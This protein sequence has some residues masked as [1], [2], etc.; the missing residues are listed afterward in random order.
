MIWL[1]EML[2]RDPDWE[3]PWDKIEKSLLASLFRA[4]GETPQNPRYHGEGDVWT[5]TKQVCTALTGLEAFRQESPRGQAVLFLG[6]LLHDLGKIRCTRW[7][8]DRWTSPNHAAVGSRM[9][10]ALLLRDL[11]LGGTP[12]Q[13]EFREAVCLLIRY[14]SLPP[15]AIERPD[16][17]WSLRRVAANGSLAPDFTLERLCLLSEADALGRICPD[18]EDMADRVRLCWELAEEAGCLLGPYPFPDGHTRYAYLSGREVAPS[19]PL[20]DDTWGPVLLMAGLPGT[21]KDTWLRQH[22]PDLPMISLDEIRKELGYGHTGDQSPV[23]EEACRRSRILL[24]Q[25][26]PF[27]WNATNVLTAYRRSQ[28]SLFEEY[29]A[30]VRI[31]YLETPWAERIRRNRGRE[32]DKVVPGEAV[33]RML[34]SLTLPEAW[35]SQSVDWIC[36]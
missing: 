16:G 23:L 19:V 32:A 12:E 6:A 18:R 24:R 33:E 3:I 26:Q 36:I 25:K 22:Y 27:V 14:H 20:Y 31:V 11:D 29:G 21:G 10:R 9:A 7:E 28:I 17:H 30:R 2:P 1:E 5:H 34:E 8:D 4:M 13:V 15:Y 35:E